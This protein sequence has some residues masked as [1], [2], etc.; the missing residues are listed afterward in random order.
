M[1]SKG[2]LRKA[3]RTYHV[4]LLVGVRTRFQSSLGPMSSYSDDP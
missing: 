1:A 4:V 3:T 2:K